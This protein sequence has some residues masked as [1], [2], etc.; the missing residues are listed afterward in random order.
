MPRSST[1][2]SEHYLRIKKHL[3]GVEDAINKGDFSAAKMH[4]FILHTSAAR[5]LTWI[6]DHGKFEPADLSG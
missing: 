2:Y 5:L 6:E 3:R 1:D 4:S